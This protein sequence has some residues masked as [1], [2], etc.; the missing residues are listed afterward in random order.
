VQYVSPA[1]SCYS[2]SCHRRWHIHWLQSMLAHIKE[3][4]HACNLAVATLQL[5][6]YVNC[7]FLNA[8]SDTYVMLRGCWQERVP[9]PDPSLSCSGRNCRLARVVTA[10][11]LVYSAYAASAVTVAELER[12]SW[13]GKAKREHEKIC[14]SS[15]AQLHL[16]L[17]FS[18]QSLDQASPIVLLRHVTSA[19]L[20]R[21]AAS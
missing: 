5:C 10:M 15:S 17:L 7:K 1:V 14:H 2:P 19:A 12:K 8:Q 16:L 13:A 11:L 4:L 9:G 20:V 18:G 6:I 3:Q 21:S